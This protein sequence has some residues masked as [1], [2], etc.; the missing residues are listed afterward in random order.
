MQHKMDDKRFD[1]NTFQK[2]SHLKIHNMEI[3]A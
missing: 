1:V 3:N 2:L